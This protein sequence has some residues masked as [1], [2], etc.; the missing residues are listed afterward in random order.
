MSRNPEQATENLS[1]IFQREQYLMLETLL[2]AGWYI[3]TS[4]GYPGDALLYAIPI[5]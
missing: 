4:Y 5:P 3:N 2:S 1:G